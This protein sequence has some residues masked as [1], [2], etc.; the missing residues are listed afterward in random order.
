M[1]SQLVARFVPEHL[2]LAGGLELRRAEILI[3]TAWFILLW[4]PPTLAFGYVTNG[5]DSIFLVV[6]ACSIGFASVP[7]ILRATGSLVA[8]SNTLIAALLVEMLWYGVTSSGVHASTM[9]AIIYAPLFALVFQTR[10]AGLAWPVIA[11]GV[12][13]GLFVM[14]AQGYPFPGDGFDTTTRAAA[15]LFELSS[16]SSVIF[17]LVS[18]K[19]GMQEFLVA[20]LR[21]REAEERPRRRCDSAARDAARA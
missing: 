5:I 12:W 2:A 9:T 17:V 16:A 1:L 11:L 8:A 10:R 13:T 21:A 3:K 20:T 19:D 14:E 18:L 7:F 4:S 6:L 15:R